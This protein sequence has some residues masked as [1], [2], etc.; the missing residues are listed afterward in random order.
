MPGPS[1]SVVR[2]AAICEMFRSQSLT[3]KVVLAKSWGDAIGWEALLE[4][5]TRSTFS[6]FLGHR[7]RLT[8]DTARRLEVELIE[9]TGPPEGRPFSLVFRGPRDVRLEQRTYP[10]EHEGIGAFPLFIVP[11]GIDEQGL[12]YEAVFN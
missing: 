7:F 8:V 4:T 1:K 10:F 12:R 3:P 11:I 5:F 2:S 6:P 9:A